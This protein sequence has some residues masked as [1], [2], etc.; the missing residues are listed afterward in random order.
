M[1]FQK[2]NAI[3]FNYP[4]FSNNCNN[5]N[6]TFIEEEY[7]DEEYLY[8][9]NDE[10]EN[11]TN[12]TIS[13]DHLYT[14]I[15]DDNNDFKFKEMDSEEEAIIKQE[16]ENIIFE[17]FELTNKTK[18]TGKSACKYCENY[19]KTKEMLRKHFDNCK[20]LQCDKRN[21]IC[22]ICNKE[23]SKKTFSNHLHESLECQY[24]FKS[25]VNPRN[26]K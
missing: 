20:Y 16:N 25:F 2:K 21:Y 7:L 13:N 11:A 8:E 17:P 3:I 26:L 18:L 6:E 23:L 19:F 5:Q 4:C 15:S 14:M 9:I 1:N 24:C 22:R 10:A 12:N